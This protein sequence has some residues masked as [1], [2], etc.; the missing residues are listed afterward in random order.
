VRNILKD[1]ANAKIIL[2]ALWNLNKITKYEIIENQSYQA[3]LI[4]N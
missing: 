2:I 1:F 4:C 3:Y